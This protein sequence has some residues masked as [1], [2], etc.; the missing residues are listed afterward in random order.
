MVRYV[1]LG[2]V[3]AWYDEHGDGLPL[4][5]PDPGGADARVVT[6]SFGVAINDAA[7]SS[8]LQH[9]R[10]ARASVDPTWGRRA[11]YCGAKGTSVLDLTG[12]SRSEPPLDERLG[13]S[14]TV[15]RP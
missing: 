13:L 2:E 7:G 15:R 14:A 11:A 4:V 12:G 8:K 6:G 9:T 5:L 1:Q 3:R 10:R